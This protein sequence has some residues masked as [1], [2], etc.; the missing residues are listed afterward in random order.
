MPMARCG[1]LWWRS[2]P[3]LITRSTTHGPQSTKSKSTAV[4]ARWTVHR[5]ASVLE[6]MVIMFVSLGETQ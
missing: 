4:A 1:G 5:R 3:A 2:W 6:I